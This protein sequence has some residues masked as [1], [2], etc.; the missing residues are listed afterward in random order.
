MNEDSTSNF[1]RRFL[2][3][4]S[5][6]WIKGVGSKYGSASSAIIGAAVNKMFV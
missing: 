3:L 1:E 5:L 6:F 4:E 2:F